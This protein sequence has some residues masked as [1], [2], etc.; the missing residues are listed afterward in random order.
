MGPN[1]RSGEVNH[2]PSNID[3]IADDS[4]DDIFQDEGFMPV[5]SL[6]NLMKLENDINV[7][8]S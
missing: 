7:R 4:D 3:M 2:D 8:E 6:A 5:P 1:P